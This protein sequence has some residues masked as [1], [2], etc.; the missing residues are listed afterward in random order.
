MDKCKIVITDNLFE[1]C[2]IEKKILSSIDADIE[3]YK[4][5]S[6]DELKEAVEYADALLVNMAEINSE[7]IKHMKNCKV[8]SRYGVGYDNVDTIAAAEAGIKVTIIPDYCVHEVAEHAFAL[9]LSFERN[10]ALRAKA[11]K[12][13]KWRDKPSPKI[14]RIHGS[15]LGIIGYGHTGKA[16]KKMAEGFGFSEILIHSRG[17]VDG[18][19]I[20]NSVYAVS[21]DTLLKESDYI[22]IHLPLNEETKYFINED[23]FNLMKNDSVLINTAR[24]AIINETHLIEALKSGKIRGAAIDVM[25]HEPPAADN[26]LCTLENII[27]TDHR[28]YYSEKSLESLKEKCAVN[29]L[30]VLKYGS[31]EFMV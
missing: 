11:V 12:E 8:I 4:N 25:E 9:L 17:L 31:A 28:A 24:G 5:L 30:S 15:V 2:D 19:K 20:D 6:F 16:L 23:S 10:I 14:K 13:G 18:E 21:L 22:S 26:Q 7:I 27:I 3:I 1:N 29:A